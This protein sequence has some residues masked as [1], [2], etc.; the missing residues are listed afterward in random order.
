MLS[1]VLRIHPLGSEVTKSRLPES[2]YRKKM[3]GYDQKLQFIFF[4]GKI[5]VGC[6]IGHVVLDVTVEI[7][8]FKLLEVTEVLC[9]GIAYYYNSKQKHSSFGNG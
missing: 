9:T 8:T 1:F 4:E 3:T 6:R 2:S 5:R 7:R